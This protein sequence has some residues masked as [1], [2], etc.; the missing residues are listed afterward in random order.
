MRF[1]ER[2]Y[3]MLTSPMHGVEYIKPF[4]MTFTSVVKFA[5]PLC[6]W[7]WGLTRTH[8]KESFTNNTWYGSFPFIGPK[9]LK[10]L[11]NIS[12]LIITCKSLGG[13][14][15]F[16]CVTTTES[17]GGTIYAE[18]CLRFLHE[19]KIKQ[20]ARMEKQILRFIVCK[21]R[22]TIAQNKIQFQYYNSRQGFCLLS[23]T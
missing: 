8:V 7:S 3:Q 20:V 6:K 4:V 19:A 13:F 21:S 5:F 23:V 22:R 1:F 10:H 17:F 15:L 18:V 16:G 2:S 12:S 9:A 14:V 11:F